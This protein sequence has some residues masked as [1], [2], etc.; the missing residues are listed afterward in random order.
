MKIIY[1]ENQPNEICS[2]LTEKASKG[3]FLKPENGSKIIVTKEKE[4]RKRMSE[5]KERR[6]RK[7]SNGCTLSFYNSYFGDSFWPKKL[8]DAK[9]LFQK[10]SWIHIFFHD[11]I[12]CEEAVEAIFSLRQLCWLSCNQKQFFKEV[13]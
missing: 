8:L 3:R 7:K 2:H 1:L 5:E 9:G 10:S 4:R 12:A 6:R 13:K 11:K